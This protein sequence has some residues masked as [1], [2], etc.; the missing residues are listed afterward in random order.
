[1]AVPNG[2]YIYTSVNSGATWVSA[3]ILN[4]ALWAAT[5]SAD[6]AEMLV[7]DDGSTSTGGG[8][9]MLQSTPKPVLRLNPLGTNL[10]VAWPV[11]SSWFQLQ[12]NS[13]VSTT[14][15]VDVPATTKLNVATLNNEVLLSAGQANRFFRLKH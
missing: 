11:P 13:D 4:G 6:G 7:A 10:V 9:Y 1:V 15:W 5:C 12:E 3:H 14:N 2:S 8:L